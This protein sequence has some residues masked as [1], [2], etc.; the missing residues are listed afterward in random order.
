MCIRDRLQTARTIWGQNFN[1]TQNVS[2]NMTGVG[3]IAMSGNIYMNNARNI[4]AKNTDGS[5]MLIFYTNSSNELVIGTGNAQ[6]EART[7]LSG[8]EIVFRT[9]T[10]LN[11][12]M[13]ISANGNVGIGTTNPSAKLDIKGNQDLIH[14][15]ATNSG[16]EYNY[17]KAYN[18]DYDSSFRFVEASNKV[19]WF[20]YGK[21]GSN[22]LYLSLIHI[23]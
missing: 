3:N 6:K 11:E 22:S 21:G 12:R 1:G 4:Y 2:G 14:L 15:Q 17:I 20:Q 23:C 7:Y 8:L 9:S 13:R 16:S 19:L 10:D 5:D 18:T